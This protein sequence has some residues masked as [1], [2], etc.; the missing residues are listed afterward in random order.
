MT[1]RR[2]CPAC[3]PHPKSRREESLKVLLELFG[4]GQ[5]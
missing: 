4:W 3:H 5:A 1:R 2:K